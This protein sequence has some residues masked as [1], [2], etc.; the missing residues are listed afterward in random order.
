MSH[1]TPPDDDE[2]ASLLSD[3]DARAWFETH[4]E[5]L[6]ENAYGQGFLYSVLVVTFIVGLGGYVAGYLLK[7]TG[8]T[9]PLALLADMLYTFGF[10]LWT[11]AV[12]VVL[13][14][15]V[16]EAKRRQVRRALE[17]Y[18]ATRGTTARDGDN[19]TARDR[20][21]TTRPTG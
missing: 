4:R 20:D 6:R 13:L 3:P 21:N 15:I 9:E 10:A 17:V 14:E 19:T 11:A 7:S 12:I 16:P 8:P 1:T 5:R 18:E 2:L